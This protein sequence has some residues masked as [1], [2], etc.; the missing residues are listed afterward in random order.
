MD[1]EGEAVANDGEE[2]YGEK[3]GRRRVLYVLPEGLT[4][5]EE[6]EKSLREEKGEEVE[7]RD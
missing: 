2:F 3:E 1:G 5:T 7:A 4:R 6:L